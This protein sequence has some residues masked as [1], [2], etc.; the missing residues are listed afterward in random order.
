MPEIT[1]PRLKETVNVSDRVAAFWLRNGWKLAGEQDTGLVL[2]FARSKTDATNAARAADLTPGQ[3]QYVDAPE[4]LEGIGA[5]LGRPHIVTEHF[6]EH[7]AHSAI[8]A[9]AAAAGLPT[10]APTTPDGD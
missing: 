1:H 8:Q 4:D 7:P 3:W 2:V 10:L 6:T 9:A 5:D